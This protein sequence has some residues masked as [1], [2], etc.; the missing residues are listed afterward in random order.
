MPKKELQTILAFL[1]LI[2]NKP[3]VT[4]SKKNK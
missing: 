2:N 3:L 4:F 1:H